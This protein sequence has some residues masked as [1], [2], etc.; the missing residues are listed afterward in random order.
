[1]EICSSGPA[2]YALTLYLRVYLHPTL[3]AGFLELDKFRSPTVEIAS[4][5]SKGRKFSR[6]KGSREGK[7]PFPPLPP[8]FVAAD[9]K[10]WVFAYFFDR[11][12]VVEFR[13]SLYSILKVRIAFSTTLFTHLRVIRTRLAYFLWLCASTLGFSGHLY[14]NLH[15]K[16]ARPAIELPSRK[17]STESTGN[18]FCTGIRG[19]VCDLDCSFLILRLIQDT[20]A[21]WLIRAFPLCSCLDTRQPGNVFKKLDTRQSEI[22]T[23]FL[24]M[25]R[26]IPLRT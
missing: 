9:R 19:V 17:A 24:E 23:N 5:S 21:K 11:R 10:A 20:M 8:S 14:S 12:S 4:K 2:D 6:L 22:L 15:S 25:A 16:V 18:I 7:A 1:M 13:V 3:Q 26:L